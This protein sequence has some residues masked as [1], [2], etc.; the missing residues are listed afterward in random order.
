M[1]SMLEQA[2]ID[3]AALREAA[4][5]SAEHAVIEKYAPEIKAAVATLLENNPPRFSRGQSVRYEGRLATVTVE[6]DQGKIGIQEVDGGKTYLVQE[7]D[8]EEANDSLL[9][10]EEVDEGTEPQSGTSNAPLAAVDLEQEGIQEHEQIIFEFTADDFLEEAEAS[11]AGEDGIDS[12]IDHGTQDVAQVAQSETSPEEGG[13]TATDD[14]VLNLNEEEID[15]DKTL[16]ELVDI[17]NEFDEEEEETVL[18]VDMQGDAKD[19]QIRTD[20]GTMEYYQEMEK[21]R[22][23]ASETQAE[24]DAKELELDEVKKL[25][26]QQSNK[27]T[28]IVKDLN[29]KLQSTLL[30][31]AKLLY[32]NRALNDAS[33][34]ERQKTKIVEAINKAHTVEEAKTLHETLRVTVG[35]HNRK[36]PQSLNET[37]SRRSN[38]SS[39]LTSKKQDSEPTDNFSERMRRLAGLK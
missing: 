31:N 39:M 17:L 26:K 2:I 29:E 19:G 14:P 28:N 30:S 23:E 18:N 25:F 12:M 11:A 22:E 35:Q 15:E 13:S 34:N 1:S 9:Q 37:V 24:L 8:I 20:K 5:K 4:L 36:S 38:L 6:N 21:A 33:L 16:Q 27:F 32:S 3:A 10:E 7:S